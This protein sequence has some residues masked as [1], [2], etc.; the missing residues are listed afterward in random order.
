VAVAAA[1]VPDALFAGAAP[2]DVTAAYVVKHVSSA[3]TA[4]EP[5][6]IARITVTR[7]VELTTGKTVTTTAKEWSYGDQWRS[8]TNSPS[9]K[10]LYD[11]GFSASSVYTLVSFQTRTWA[12]QRGLGRP[13]APV[14]DALG[15]GFSPAPL[16]S[17]IGLGSP[18][19]P[20]PSPAGASLAYGNV[21]LPRSC[22]PVVAA[23][24][25]LFL[26]GLPGYGFSASSLPA[27]RALR[28]AISCG[29]LTVAGRQRVDGIDTIKLTSRPHSPIAETVWVTLHTYLPVRVIVRSNGGRPVAGVSAVRQQTADITWLPPT[30]QNRANLTVSIPPGFRRVRELPLALTLRPMVLRDLADQL[31][32]VFCL[33]PDGPGCKKRAGALG[34]TGGH[35]GN[36]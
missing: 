13:N 19:V 11:E 3:L 36:P 22:G 24:P 20:A 2:Q 8:V 33:G 25:W 21:V 31:P 10:P 15:L 27:A 14:S 9:G 35:A 26:P 16:S 1:V 30:A 4:A 6:D 5:G 29:A 34:Y 28:N 12:R 17:P 23:L 7:T 32:V 18:V